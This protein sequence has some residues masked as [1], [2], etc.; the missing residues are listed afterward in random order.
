[1]ANIRFSRGTKAAFDSLTSLSPDQLYFVST[2]TGT[3]NA[4]KFDSIYIGLESGNSVIAQLVATSRVDLLKVP[5]TVNKGA[6]YYV[7]DS[8]SLSALPAPTLSSGQKKYL[9]INNSGTLEWG[10][11]GLDPQQGLTPGSYSNQTAATLDYGS[12]PD[13]G[14]AK[15]FKVPK[16]TVDQYGVVTAAE[17]V[18]FTMP[19]AKNIVGGSATAYA[20]AAVTGN[21]VFVNLISKN[22]ASGVQSSFKIQGDSNSTD[23][24]SI[25]VRSDASGNITVACEW[26]SL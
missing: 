21:G 5:S 16:L 17:D 9:T 23:N 4:K 22:S 24:G 3:G 8:H 2:D 12:T 19:W 1:M 18:T 20:N 15:T 14:A 11:A 7:N 6:L 13:T 25:K 10:S 26:N